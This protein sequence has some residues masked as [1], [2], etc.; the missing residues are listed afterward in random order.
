MSFSN[1]YQDPQRA[2]AYARLEFPNTYYL[3][4]RDLPDIISR[5]A[6]GKLAVDFGCGTGRSSRF[7]Q[8]LGYKVIGLDI[9]RDMVDLA[10]KADPEGQYQVIPN[11]DFSS[12]PKEHYDLVA[13]IFTF[14]N[15]PG[16]SNRLF[17]LK[18]LAELIHSGGRIVLLDSTPEIYIN[19]WAS[20]TTKDFP[21]NKMAQSGETVRIV[22]TDVEDRRPVEDTIWFEEDYLEL[23]S[24]ANLQLEATYRPLGKKEEPFG[25]KSELTVAPWVIYVLQK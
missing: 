16:K 5:H 23:F 14:D 8:K 9:S 11:G 6:S 20:F 13:S 24:K 10:T 3:A 22:M 15:I 1:V 4:Y 7:I 21:E 19:E 17:I 18:G 12:L 25:W 2:A